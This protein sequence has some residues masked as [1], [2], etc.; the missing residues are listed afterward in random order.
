M[1]LKCKLLTI[2]SSF[3]NNY[4]FKDICAHNSVSCFLICLKFKSLPLLTPTI[5]FHSS[6]VDFFNSLNSFFFA[7]VLFKHVLFLRQYLLTPY[8]RRQQF[9]SFL[10]THT[11]LILFLHHLNGQNFW[12]EQYSVLT[13]ALLWKYNSQ[14]SPVNVPISFSFIYNFLFSLLYPLPSL[15]SLPLYIY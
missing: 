1:K 10:H 5:K 13:L 4:C 3:K 7:S 8:H 11:L 9:M 2:I 14:K 6:K 12:V 15:V